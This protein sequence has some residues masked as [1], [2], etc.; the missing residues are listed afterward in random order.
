[1]PEM[2][3]IYNENMLILLAVIVDV[4]SA[5]IQSDRLNRAARHQA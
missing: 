5:R 1:M 2:M 4:V 3:P